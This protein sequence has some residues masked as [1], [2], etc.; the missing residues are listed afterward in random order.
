VNKKG[1]VYIIGNNRPTVYIGVTSD[2]RKR[3]WQ[4]KEDLVKGF[5]SKYKLHK[6]LYYEVFENI[7]LAIRR[8][9]QL[10]NW[11]R[12]WK[13]DLIRSINPEFIDL[14]LNIE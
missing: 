12:G 8:E 13:I 4:H 7:E 14:Y 1:Y 11:R 5:S 9:K 6:L 10:K 3:I 2:L